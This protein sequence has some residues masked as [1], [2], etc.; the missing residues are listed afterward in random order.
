[1]EGIGGHRPVPD[2]GMRVQGVC[3]GWP[4][5]D[6]QRPWR[7]DGVTV[8]QAVAG[9]AADR[10]VPQPAPC[11]QRQPVLGKPV[12]DT[13]IPP[14]IPGPVWQ[15]RG[16]PGIYPGLCGLVQPR[17]SPRGD[18][19][20]HAGGGPLGKGGGSACGTVGD[21]GQGARQEPGPLCPGQARGE[22]A[23]QGGLDQP[24]VNP[25][26]AARHPASFGPKGARNETGISFGADLCL[27]SKGLALT[28]A[29]PLPQIRLCT[30]R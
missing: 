25:S 7:P 6:S 30:C 16:S 5:D 17:A 26:Q 10:E 14:G 4:A 24:A 19:P 22:T 15:L 3:G 8:G 20:A 2:P 11:L 23:A 9:E 12:Q 13:E 28:A 29:I 21:D 27:A 1:M 18:Q